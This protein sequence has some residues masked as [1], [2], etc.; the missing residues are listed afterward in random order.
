MFI[1]EDIYIIVKTFYEYL[2]DNIDIY[3]RH[4]G[5]MIFIGHD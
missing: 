3:N 2:Y 1:L 4:H 5:E